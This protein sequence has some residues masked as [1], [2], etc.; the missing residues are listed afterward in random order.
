[1]CNRYNERGEV[2][3][4]GPRCANCAQTSTPIPPTTQQQQ[5]AN[6]ELEALIAREQAYHREVYTQQL[7]QYTQHRERDMQREYE[8]QQRIQ[9]HH[10]N[11]QVQYRHN[12]LQHYQQYQME[13]QQQHAQQRAQQQQQ[14]NQSQNQGQ[15]PSPGGIYLLWQL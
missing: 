1:M 5:P 13:L 12:G 3:W 15:P 10:Q 4:Y 2:L 14:Q 6:T 8:R 9:L 11:Q 7:E